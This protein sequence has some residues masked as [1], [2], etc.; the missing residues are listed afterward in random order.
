ITGNAQALQIA[1]IVQK[2]QRQ[3]MAALN[4]E[5]AWVRSYSGYITKTSHDPDAIRRAGQ[6]KWIAD[7]LPRL[8]LVR[9]FGTKD[10]TRA[11]D[12]LRAMFAPMSLGDH[13]DYGRPA[14][15]PLY[16]TP[17]KTASAAREL[18]FKS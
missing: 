7:T 18:H 2:W 10:M 13:F 15:E 6:E 8:D 14:D 5:G 3:S 1:K 9:T 16:P 12:A 11:R 4:R 17:A